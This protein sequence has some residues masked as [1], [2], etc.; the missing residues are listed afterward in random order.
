MSGASLAVAQRRQGHMAKPAAQVKVL[1]V[2]EAPQRPVKARLT[3]H[4]HRLQLPAGQLEVHRPH[5]IGIHQPTDALRMTMA[6]QPRK[7][8]GA[9]PRLAID[10]HPAQR[11]VMTHQYDGD[12]GIFH[13]ASRLFSR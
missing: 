10:H 5:L 11:A 13:K 2:R 1:R 3:E 4:L 6:Q 9:D 12:K 7:L 8:P